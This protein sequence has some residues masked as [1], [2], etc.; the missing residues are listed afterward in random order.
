MR[1][2]GSI[3]PPQAAEGWDQATAAPGPLVTPAGVPDAG[4]GRGGGVPAWLAGVLAFATVASLVLVAAPVWMAR[5]RR[6]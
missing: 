4:S 2:C 6:S 5:T 3:D 1:A